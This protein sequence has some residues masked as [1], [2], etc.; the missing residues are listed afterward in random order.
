MGIPKTATPEEIRK[1]HRKLVIKLHPDKGGDPEKFKEMQNAYEVLSDPKKREIYDKYGEEG[2]KNGGA[3]FDPFDFFGD[4]GPFRTRSSQNVKRK[5]KAKLVELSITLEDSYNG[6]RKEVE[7][8]RRIVC[9]KC[10]GTGSANPDAKT[11]CSKCNG[12][13][14]RLIVQRHGPMIMQT[15]TTCDECNGEG[16]IIKDKCKECKGKMVKTIKRKIGVDLERGVPDGHRYKMAC[17]GDEFPEVE[18][19]DLIIE[20]F[21]NKHKTFIRKGADLIY[22]CEI[23]LLEAL[24]GVKFAITHLDGRRILIQSKPG[25]IIQPQTLKTVEELGMPFFNSPFRFGNLYIDF[26]IAFPDK[27]SDEQ[28]TKITEILNNERLNHVSNITKDIEKATFEEYNASEANSS[29]KGGKKEDWK[30]EDDDDE[31]EEGAY[32]KTVNCS[33]Q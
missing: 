33:N 23:S 18:T 2:L 9:P 11:T 3:E 6:G 4:F 25:E 10:K 16:K 30:G 20:I 8:E 14:V 15:Q 29:Y 24:T 32:H 21:L 28:S 1:A 22:K 27:F 7:Y 17:E 31:D 12:S 26:H 5:C 13:G 19:G